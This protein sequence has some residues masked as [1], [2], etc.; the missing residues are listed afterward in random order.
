[1][2]RLRKT[3]R[4]RDPSFGFW[5]PTDL[6]VQCDGPLRGGGDAT[7][8]LEEHGVTGAPRAG[9]SSYTASELYDRA[10]VRDAKAMPRND[11]SRVRST[12]DSWGA[13]E[14]GSLSSRTIRKGKM[15]SRCLP[16]FFITNFEINFPVKIVSF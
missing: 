6:I 2:E 7:G 14:K 11:Y 3:A 9:Q 13:S 5:K 8:A 12:G 10:P 1:L 16:S 4:D 15:R